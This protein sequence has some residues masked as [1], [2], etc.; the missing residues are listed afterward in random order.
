VQHHEEPLART[1]TLVATF[2]QTRPFA[3]CVGAAGGA[4]AHCLIYTKVDF[5]D[6]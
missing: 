4:A 5:H 3:Q 1:V 6:A 2:P